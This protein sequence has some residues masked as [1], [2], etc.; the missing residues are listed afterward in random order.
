M[1]N[2]TAMEKKNS[3]VVTPER[4]KSGRV[5]SPPVDI[6]ETPEELLLV[7]DVPGATAENIDIRFEQGEL[8]LS[9]QVTP[10]QS[11]TNRFLLREYGVGDYLR[12]FSIGESIDPAQIQAEAQNGVLVIHLPKVENAKPR[13]IEVKGA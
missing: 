8:T 12:V 10:R 3:E 4:M 6:I 9:A 11:E 2:A 5:Y 13:K 7:A 1:A